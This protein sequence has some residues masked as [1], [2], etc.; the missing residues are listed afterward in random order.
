MLRVEQRQA[1]EFANLRFTVVQPD[2]PNFLTKIEYG[3]VA[4][5]AE[6]FDIEEEIARDVFC[7]FGD[8]L[9]FSFSCYAGP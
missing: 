4:H 5:D 3:L 1:S 7:R 2:D 6:Q 8:V 9:H